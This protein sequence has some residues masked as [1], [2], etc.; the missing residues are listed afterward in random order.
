MR[1]RLAQK[2]HGPVQVVQLQRLDAWDPVVVSPSLRGPITPRPEQA[3]Q[4]GQE[5]RPLHRE[6]E[7]PRRQLL[8]QGIGDPRRVPQR[9]KHQ[10]GAD[11]RQ[12]D[13]LGLALRCDDLAPSAAATRKIFGTPSLAA[14]SGTALAVVLAQPVD[15]D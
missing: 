12:P 8:G 5:D 9:A 1:L 7:P 10:V 11:L 15:I 4:H 6:V 14:V 2:G 13:R 3:M